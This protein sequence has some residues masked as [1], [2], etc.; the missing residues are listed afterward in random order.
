TFGV[1]EYWIVDPDAESTL[2]Q[3]L[4]NGQYQPFDSHD[5]LLH[6]KHTAG[7]VLDPG[8]IFSMPDWLVTVAKRSL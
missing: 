4:I 7:L 5:G 2:A 3:E 6:S 1:P 8:E